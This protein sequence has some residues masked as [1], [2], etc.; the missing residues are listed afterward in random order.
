M[1]LATA[2]LRVFRPIL[3]YVER[4][5][6]S[7][8]ESLRKTLLIPLAFGVTIFTSLFIPFSLSRGA[9][10]SAVISIID[11]FFVL[12]FLA[13]VIV[14]KSCPQHIAGTFASVCG[15]IPILADFLAYG[16]V[17]FYITG[18]L[19]TDVLLLCNCH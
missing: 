7:K 11:V 18:V 6:D 14:T 1:P 19:V 10:V 2:I 13:Y 12:T 15:S 5:D 9:A 16:L 8:D 4:P 3:Q 17:D